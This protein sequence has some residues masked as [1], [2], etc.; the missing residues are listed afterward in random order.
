VALHRGIDGSDPLR[1][2]PIT[3]LQGVHEERRTSGA[4][5]LGSGTLACP[6][7]DAPVALAGRVMSPVEALHCPFCRHS[8]A[9]RDFLS[10]VTPARPARVEIRIV[11]PALR[12]VG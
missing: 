6:E 5:R 8:A 11:A 2:Q 7:C 10:L 1:A 4:W 9:L 3:R 12:A